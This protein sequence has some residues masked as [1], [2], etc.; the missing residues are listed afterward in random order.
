MPTLVQ[1]PVEVIIDDT[2]DEIEA[3]F[4]DEVPAIDIENDYNENGYDSDDDEEGGVTFINM[5]DS[6]MFKYC[7][8]I[9]GQLRTELKSSHKSL[10]TDFVIRELLRYYGRLPSYRAAYYCKKLD[11][12]Y[13]E[14]GYYRDVY[15]WLPEVLKE[16]D[17][18]TPACINCHSCKHVKPHAW[19]EWPCRRVFDMSQSYY[20]MTRRY[21]CDHCKKVAETK[22]KG[23]KP[24][25]T[26]MGWHSLALSHTAFGFGETFPAHLSSRSGISKTVLRL[27]R[28][29]TGRGI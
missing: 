19:P 23:E 20:I 26:Y 15:I 16:D 5:K 9:Q 25:Y 28:A 8:G 3:I 7:A 14:E 2:S 21:R 1:F 6:I 4:T 17:Q 13:F 12:K 10:P 22:P 29:T 24:Q 27:L 18:Y 11:L